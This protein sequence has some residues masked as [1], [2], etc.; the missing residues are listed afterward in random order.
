MIVAIADTHALLWYLWNDSRLTASAQQVFES[1]AQNGDEIGLSA[2]S[3]VEVVSL[4]EKGRIPAETLDAV[5][6]LLEQNDSLLQEIPVSRAIVRAMQQVPRRE[7]PDMPD[8]VIAAP[9]MQDQV[10]LASRDRK[11]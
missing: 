2:I 10:P 8:R 11:I 9:A 1:A 5:V 4:I 6:N 3:L 7:A